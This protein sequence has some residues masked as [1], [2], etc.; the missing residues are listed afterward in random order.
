MYY[1]QFIKERIDKTQLSSNP[2]DSTPDLPADDDDDSEPT[3]YPTLDDPKA[4]KMVL[5]NCL[6]PK[7]TEL[8]LYTTSSQLCLV[9]GFEETLKYHQGWMQD[10]VVRTA[11]T[12]EKLISARNSEMVGVK[13]H[14]YFMFDKGPRSGYVEQQEIRELID[15]KLRAGMNPLIFTE[16]TDKNKFFKFT[17]TTVKDWKVVNGKK[18]ADIFK[19]AI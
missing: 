4:E 15:G 5:Q 1:Y 17:N 11:K 12:P 3:E 9:G 14:L 2:Y 6:K 18:L 10:P 16:I 7:N 19:K 13:F 8:R